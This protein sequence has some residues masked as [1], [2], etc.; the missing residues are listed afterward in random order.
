M[1]GK[2]HIENS[3]RAIVVAF[4]LIALQMGTVHMG[5][6][7]ARGDDVGMMMEQGGCPDSSCLAAASCG[8]SPALTLSTAYTHSSLFS[9]SLQ[10]AV[11]E[12]PAELLIKPPIVA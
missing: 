9:L 3:L 11:P 1:C 2:N 12:S 10:T 7:A 8:L 5:L 4:V 6:A